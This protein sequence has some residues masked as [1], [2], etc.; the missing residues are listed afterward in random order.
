MND[1]RASEPV[2]P[3]N[4]RSGKPPAT[5]ARLLI[6]IFVCVMVVTAGFSWFI[7]RNVRKD[8]KL[9]DDHL[10][11]VAWG[12]LLHVDRAGR[13]PTSESE[14]ASTP[15][16]SAVA[17]DPAHRWPTIAEEAGLGGSAVDPALADS[18]AQGFP[19]RLAESLRRL[20]VRF[21]T[22]PRQPPNLTAGGRA[23][24]LGTLVEL[25]GWLRGRADALAVP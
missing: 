22:D 14:L 13:F 3:A 9:A 4:G 16:A 24:G 25:N 19:E 11:T 18:I 8:A 2:P 23:T 6:I 1:P 12:V 10:R 17:V 20:D 21:S 15:F 7:A 5:P